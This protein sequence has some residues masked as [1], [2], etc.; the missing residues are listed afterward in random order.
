MN[1]STPTRGEWLCLLEKIVT[2]VLETGARGALGAE[3]P[4]ETHPDTPRSH[5]ASVSPLEA[6]GSS[7]AGIAPWLA[8]PVADPKEEQ[9][10][11]KLSSLAREA[12]TR[13]F[14]PA[15]PGHMPFWRETPE[16]GRSPYFPHQSLVDASYLARALLYARE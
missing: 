9:L 1:T 12:I 5:R 6:L 14:A 13:A 8:K 10:R 4:V 3:M 11:R 7:L 16:P 2:P 15:G